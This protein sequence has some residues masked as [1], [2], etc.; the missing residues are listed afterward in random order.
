MT[1]QGGW[2]GGVP[3]DVFLSDLSGTR[4]F[5]G[6]T[7]DD[8]NAVGKHSFTTF[9]TETAFV[10]EFD[11]IH[12][13]NTGT[14]H[15]M[16]TRVTNA[17][18]SSVAMELSILFNCGTGDSTFTLGDQSG[19]APVTITVA[20]STTV[21]HHV[22]ITVRDTGGNFILEL[23]GVEVLTYHSGSPTDWSDIGNFVMLLYQLGTSVNQWRGKSL[24][25][26]A[27]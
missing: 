11:Y 25:L 18:E 3:R 4:V 15:I 16:T 5:N 19:S 21:W 14:T 8:E 9:T 13:T 17:G 1:G 10:L 27:G 24:V 20:P 23:D 6:P 12:R 7:A 22:K 26:S 2:T